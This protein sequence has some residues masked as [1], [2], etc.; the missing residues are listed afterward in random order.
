MIWNHRLLA[1]ILVGLLFP[2]LACSQN[3]STATMTLT[4]EPMSIG[5]P[6]TCTFGPPFFV[7][8]PITVTANYNDSC[9]TTANAAS[10]P[11]TQYFTIS[12]SVTGNG[13]CENF[14]TRNVSCPPRMVNNVMLASGPTDFNRFFNQ[15]FDQSI[16]FDSSGNA[17]CAQGAFRQD[18]EQCA[19]QA[20]KTGGGGHP[21][22]DPCVNPPNGGITAVPGDDGEVTSGG[23]GGNVTPTCSPIIVDIGEEGFHLTSAQGGVPFDIAGTGHPVQIAWTNQY[24]RNAFLAL[25]GPDGL[26]HNGKELFGNFTP[27]PPSDHPNGFLALAE[28]DKL[29]NG[30]NED[31]VIDDKDAVFSR[32]RLWIDKNH[33]GICQPNEL[34]TL[35]ELG[36]SS[37]SLKYHLS[38]LKDQYGNLFRYRSRVNAAQVADQSDVGKTVYDVFLTTTNN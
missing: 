35:S 28:F 15:A 37:I 2:V 31:G 17:I 10:N 27:Q 29:E 18:F 5:A 23:G 16:G 3:C 20:C 13:Q 4:S 6:G 30:G 26:V 9:S 24:F 22:G 36:V 19:G 14:A 34:H 8:I 1:S 33:D 25:P 12:S 7:T 38:R 11:S 21:G 32:L